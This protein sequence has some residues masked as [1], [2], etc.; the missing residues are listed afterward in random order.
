MQT[1]TAKLD[2]LKELKSNVKAAHLNVCSLKSRVH[3][4]LVKDTILQNNL[5]MF[6]ISEMWADLTVSDASL[7][8][9]GYQLFRQ[10]RRSHKNGGGLC[11]Y[12]KSNLKVIALDDLSLACCDGFQQ[13]WLRML[14]R[15]Q[16]FFFSL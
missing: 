7:E 11:I 3:F 1:N 10:D 15:G 16:K 2:I 13:L 12:A 5:D 6:T 4:C 9:P 14:C 8:I